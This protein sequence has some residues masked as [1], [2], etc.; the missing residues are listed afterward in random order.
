MRTI[1]IPAIRV[2]VSLAAGDDCPHSLDEGVED[3]GTQIGEPKIWVLPAGGIAVAVP[4][5]QLVTSNSEWSRG[6][7]VRSGDVPVDRSR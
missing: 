1:A 2:I 5:E 3:L 7:G 6:V 4:V